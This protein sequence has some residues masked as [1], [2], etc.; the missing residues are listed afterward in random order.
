MPIRIREEAAPEGAASS[1]MHHSLCA[2]SSR[3]SRIDSGMHARKMA[4][5]CYQTARD[6][7]CSR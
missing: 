4:P 5:K 6:S 3:G 2:L 7:L 1:R